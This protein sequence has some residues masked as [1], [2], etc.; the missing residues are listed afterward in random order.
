ML[1]NRFGTLE[2][3]W[4]QLNEDLP[5]HLKDRM[6]SLIAQDVARVIWNNET[7]I[8]ITPILKKELNRLWEYL[9]D[10]SKPWKTSIAHTI[11]CDHNAESWGDASLEGIGF[12]SDDLET[13]FTLPWPDWIIT[14]LQQQKKNSNYFHVNEA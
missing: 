14:K 12:L 8:F 11:P 10:F 9:Q 3:R 4:N 2:K 1:Q 5:S 13:F 6:E 7:T